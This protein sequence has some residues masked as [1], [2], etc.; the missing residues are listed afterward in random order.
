MLHSTGQ[1]HAP[2]YRTTTCSTLQDNNMLHSTGQQHAPLYRTKTCSTLQD[3]NMLHST[4]QQHAPL[5]WTT[6]CSTLL[7]NNMLHSTGQQHTRTEP[8]LGQSQSSLNV[9]QDLWSPCGCS[10]A[11]RRVLRIMTVHFLADLHQHIPTFAN[12]QSFTSPEGYYYFQKIA[13]FFRKQKSVVS[14]YL[15]VLRGTQTKLSGC[16]GDSCNVRMRAT[17]ALPLPTN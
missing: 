17:F 11:L 15:A 6:T 12:R 2:L 1:Q 4:G 16:V 5:Y 13:F 9:W 14:I 10:N 3:N 8:E 7:E